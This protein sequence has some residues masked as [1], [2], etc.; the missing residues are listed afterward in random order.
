MNENQRKRF[1]F[2]KRLA[3][4]IARLYISSTISRGPL[5]RRLN[6]VRPL[7]ARAAQKVYNQW[8]PDEEGF[9]EEYGSGGI[10]DDIAYAMEDVISSYLKISAE[11]EEGGHE[12]DDHAWLIVSKG[13]EAYGVNIPPGVY[14]TGGGYRWYKRPGVRFSPGHVQIWAIDPRDLRF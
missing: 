9:D 2:Q 7:L 10:C 11:V 12:G 1:E 14:E 13:Q 6:A 4:K 3:Y 5:Y 8:Q